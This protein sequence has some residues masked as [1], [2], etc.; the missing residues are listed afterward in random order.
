LASEYS[1]LVP[2]AREVTQ[3]HV[4]EG[5]QVTADRRLRKLEHRAEL[6]HGQLLRFDQQ[7]QPIPRD[8]GEGEKI[9]ED[10]GR[11]QSVNPDI[12][13]YA[14]VWL[15]RTGSDADFLHPGTN[16]GCSRVR[17]SRLAIRSN[18][19]KEDVDASR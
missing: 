9:V 14:Q 17:W 13:I 7:E 1:R 8:V 2:S 4:G 5:L 16:G 10:G 19:A 15:S 3:P 11:A 6:R 12:M 18:R